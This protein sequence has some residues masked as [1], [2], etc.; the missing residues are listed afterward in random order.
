MEQGA[1]SPAFSAEPPFPPLRE[2]RLWFDP[3]P[4][5]GYAN[6]AADELLMRDSA[7]W[8]RVYAWARPAV[9]YG[10]FDRAEE[11]RRLF[12]AAEEYIRRWTG[13]GIVDHR[14]GQT[15]TL[16][17]PKRADGAVYPEA[18]VLYQW[19]H[20]AL[21]QALAAHG[22]PCSLLAADAPSGGRACW[23]SPVCS[24]ITDAEGHKLAGAGQRR[25]GSAVLHQGLIQDCSPTEGWA[26]DLA[27]ALAERVTVLQSAD[28][29]PGFDAQLAQLCREKYDSPAWSTE[30]DNGR[31]HPVERVDK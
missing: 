13:G 31:R 28:P 18:A 9:S 26:L 6:M 27:R 2:L 29:Y 17:L 3:H 19:I 30:T 14:R 22:V 5:R 21:A 11:A 20:G 12:P 16:T 24:D 10:Y 25:H 1:P 15:Y 8:L 4:R 23:A 7:P